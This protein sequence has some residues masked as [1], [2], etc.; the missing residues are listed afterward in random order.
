M[1]RLVFAAL[2]ALL[3]LSGF[4]QQAKEAPQTAVVSALLGVSTERVVAIGFGVLGGAVGLHA[5]LGDTVWTLAGGAA[6][7]MFGNWWYIQRLDDKRTSAKL[8]RS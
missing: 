5:L 7:A 6:G 2:V 4:A 1:R 8:T 3:P